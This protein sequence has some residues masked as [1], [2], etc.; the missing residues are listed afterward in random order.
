MDHL[1]NA[2]QLIN[3]PLQDE[4][5]TFTRNLNKAMNS[6][7]EYTNNMNLPTTFFNN[8]EFLPK[9]DFVEYADR[10]VLVAELPGFAKENISLNLVDNLLTIRGSYN[11]EFENNKYHV[12]ERNSGHFTRT[13]TIPPDTSTKI[14]ARHSDG[15]LT[16]TI[17]K[18]KV[19]SASSIPIL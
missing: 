4:V 6:L 11:E 3:S 9:C 17:P 15:I 5:T 12:Q 10:Y 13:F 19:S 18:T 8:S 7:L 2:S 16:V 14:D 1:F